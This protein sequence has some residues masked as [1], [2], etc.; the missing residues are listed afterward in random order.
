MS[1]VWSDD[2]THDETHDENHDEIHQYWW[3]E[4]GLIF[5]CVMILHW[6]FLR[7]HLDPDDENVEE[8]QEVIDLTEDAKKGDTEDP[9]W[10]GGMRADLWAKR[11]IAP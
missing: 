4:I 2:E 6:K 1:C 8:V 9:A 11:F 5:Y 10:L 7:R 3:N